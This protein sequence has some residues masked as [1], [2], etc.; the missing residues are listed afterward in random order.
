MPALIDI[1]PIL[2]EAGATFVKETG[3][4]VKQ[5]YPANDYMLKA[6]EMLRHEAGA[7][8][9]SIFG[10]EFF[11]DVERGIPPLIKFV[12]LKPATPLVRVQL[13]EWSIKK[14]YQFESDSKR[15]SFAFAL[16]R[17]ILNWGTQLYRDGGRKD[18]Y[19]PKIDAMMKTL[20]D[21]IGKVIIDTKLLN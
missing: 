9:L 4:R 13:Y 11:E 8:D 12:P 7:F 20:S 15:R 6:G 17:Y 10:W 19:T 3:E 18:I 5:V 16:R 2:N 1:S 14:G 21:K